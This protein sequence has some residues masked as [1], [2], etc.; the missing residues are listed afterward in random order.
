MAAAGS[1]SFAWPRS[2]SRTISFSRPITRK[3]PPG[4]ASTITMCSELLPRSMAAILIETPFYC[5]GMTA[6]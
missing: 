4:S 2:P 5:G 1:R 6:T 3:E